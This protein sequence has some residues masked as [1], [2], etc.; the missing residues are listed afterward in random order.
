MGGGSSKFDG[1]EGGL[2][3]ILEGSMGGLKC[4]QKIPMKEFI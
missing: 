2:K 3:S 1:G 4:C